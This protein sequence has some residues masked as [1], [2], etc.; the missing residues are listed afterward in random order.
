MI[1]STGIDVGLVRESEKRDARSHAGPQNSNPF[2]AFTLKPADRSARIK[3]ALAHRLNCATNIRADQMIGAFEIRRTAFLMIRQRQTQRGHADEVKDAAGFNV[4]LRLR[5]PLRQNY[6]GRSRLARSLFVNW[7]KSCA[8]Q[9]VFR[10][11]RMNGAG[12]G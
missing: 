1:E 3:H 12:P 6:D 10:I 8:R 7:K 11:R 5:V 4:T 9:I 2:I